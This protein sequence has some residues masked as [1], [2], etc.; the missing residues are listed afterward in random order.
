MHDVQTGILLPESFLFSD[1]FAIMST[2]VAINTVMYVALAVAKILPKIYFSD[3]IRGRNRRT[4][5]RS[6]HPD[7]PV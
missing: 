2:V 4:E 5:T 6:I 1:V 7:D 3:F